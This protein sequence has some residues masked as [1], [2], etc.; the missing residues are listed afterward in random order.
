MPIIPRFLDAVRLATAALLF[1]PAPVATLHAQGG[2]P[3]RAPDAPGGL[4]RRILLGVAVAPDSAAPGARGIVVRD[5]LPI[6]TAGAAGVR[7]GDRILALDDSAVSEV[8]AFV[9][10]A[11]RIRA[12]STVKLRLRRGADSL[13]VLARAVPRPLE[14]P[15]GLRVDYGAVTAGGVRRRT[16]TLRPTTPGRHPAVLF[17]GGVGCYSLDGV[18]E[19]GGYGALIHGL[20]RA[21]WVVMRVEKVGQGDSEGP[22]CGSPAADLHLE[23]AGYVAGMRALRADAGVDTAHVAIVAHSMGPVEASI[24]AD[25]VLPSALVL[26]ETTGMNWLEYELANLRRQLVLLGRPYDEVEQAMRL[27]VRCT[28]RF[29]VAHEAPADI[30]RAIP[31]CAGTLALPQPWTY[32]QQVGDVDQAAHL[33]RVDRPVLVMYGTSDFVTS[34]SDSRYLVDMIN[35]FHPGRASLRVVDGMD[36]GLEVAPPPREAIRRPPG[37]AAGAHPAVL[38]AVRDFLLEHG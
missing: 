23:V 32:M 1:A 8:P 19:A 2:A 22:A 13:D 37:G 21:G 36:H 33:K 25:S 24:V 5:V 29:Y 12:G 38:P 16:I 7:P 20:A 6:G 31:A 18:G 11:G 17:M 34:E 30:E 28:T 10:R 9:A 27:H 26:M 3:G 35:G 15:A 4:P 14:A